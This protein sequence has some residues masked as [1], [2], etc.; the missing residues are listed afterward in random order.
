MR[1]RRC[2][3]V[4]LEPAERLEFD[5]ARLATGGTG[6]YTVMD[7]I[8]FVPHTGQSFTLTAAEAMALGELSPSQ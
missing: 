5:L 2:G 3:L 1:V 7:W 4:M 6:L 8:A